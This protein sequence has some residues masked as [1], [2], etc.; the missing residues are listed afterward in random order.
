MVYES[1]SHKAY[2]LENPN[3]YFRLLLSLI[4]VLY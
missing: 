4:A 1:D 2:H 3:Y